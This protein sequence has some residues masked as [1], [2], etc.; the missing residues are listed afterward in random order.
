MIIPAY[1]EEKWVGKTVEA[2]KKV[3]EVEEVI[4][5][6]DGSKDRT[7]PEAWEAG[8]WV[9]RFPE[10]RGKSQAM[11]EGAW[12]ARGEVLAFLDA[13][14]GTTAGEIKRL[15]LPVLRGEADMAIGR[16]VGAGRGG[17]IGLV[18]TAAYWGIYYY[19]GK[20][21]QAPLSGQRVLTRGV[22]E[23]LRFKGSGFAAE[24]SLTVESL[25]GGFRLLE[26]PLEMSHRLTKN[27]LAGI[28]HRGRQFLDI[29]GFFLRLNGE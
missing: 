14:L 27:D 5:V 4:V 23:Q 28:K 20:K 16:L 3:E 13:D 26:V 21:L 25:Q 19:T 1:N 22:W 17:G 12:L 24:V 2:L 7:S 18:K 11:R 10:N 15:L 6:D 8:A 29:T 9:R